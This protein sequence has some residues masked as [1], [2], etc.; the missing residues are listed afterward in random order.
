MRLT[1]RFSDDE[2][3]LLRQNLFER[4]S[5][6]ATV[7]TE[8]PVVPVAKPRPRTHESPSSSSRREFGN[9][10]RMFGILNFSH[11]AVSRPLSNN[12][13]VEIA[14]SPS[15]T[16]LSS[17][18]VNLFRRATGR[19][20]TTPNKD[21][22]DESSFGSETS[23]IPRALARKS[24]VSSVNTS[25]SHALT[26]TISITSRKTNIGSDRGH[27][28]SVTS[29]SPTGTRSTA[30]SIRRFNT[31]PSSFRAVGLDNKQLGN[32]SGLYDDDRLQTS[33]DIKQ[34]ILSVEA[35]AK[36]MMDA[37]NGLELTTLTKMQKATGRN[38]VIGPDGPDR[39]WMLMPDGQSNRMNLDNDGSS[40]MSGVSGRTSTSIARSAY[41]ARKVRPKKSH[42]SPISMGHGAFLH[43]QNSSSSVHLPGAGLNVMANN[44]NLS[45][46]KS[47]GQL[48][49]RV[50]P[51]CGEDRNTI[52][53][54]DGDEMTE[55]RRRREEVMMRYDA[56]LEYLRARLK[57]AQLHEKLLRK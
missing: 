50:V 5:S 33:Q 16:S 20:S 21:L 40:I 36:S 45:L 48:P 2:Y 11:I 31:P 53:V 29:F 12:F 13:Q 17:G 55:I 14:R 7:P 19:R 25:A 30:G 18:V 37:F 6:K 57:G 9:N 23:S 10:H 22:S 44:S 26:D 4:F 34:E 15:R 54:E 51:E 8:S 1:S 24:S 46:T 35:E 43:R 42:G 49:M 38:S 27:S 56:R 39:S 47:I 41:S 52:M 32:Y 28:E 3:R